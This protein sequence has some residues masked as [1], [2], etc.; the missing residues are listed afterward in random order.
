MESKSRLDWPDK[1]TE[2]CGVFAVYAPGEDVSRLVYFGLYALQHRGQESAG[3]GVADG[4]SVLVYK[5]MGLVPQVF[6]EQN[7]SSLQGYISI[8]HVRYSTTGSTKWE[9]SQPI[10]KTLP[11]GGSIALAH[12][13][14]LVNAKELR[15]LLEKKGWQFTSSSDSEIIAQLIVEEMS[16]S[17]E[18]A[19]KKAMRQLKGAYS[20]IATTE[21]TLYAFRDPYGIRPLAL[22]QFGTSYVISSETCGL[23]IVG[24]HYLRDIQPGEL[25][26]INSQ[27]LHSEKVISLPQ[28][29]LCIFEFIYFARPD[30]RLYGQLLYHARRAMGARLAEEAPV[31]ADLVIGIPDSGT[32]AAIGYAERSRI[33][34]SEG[35]IKNRY[36]GRTFIQPSQTIR[37]LGVRLKL[38]PLKEIIRG[39][40]LVIVDDSIVRGN[41]SKKIV[42]ILREA[43]A[44]E[45]HMRISSPPVRW[46][47]FYGID[48][49]TQ[50]ELIASAKSVEKIAHFIEADSLSYLSLE[51]LVKATK[52]P[53]A[54]FCLAC[55]NNAYPISVPEDV[56][57]DKFLLEKEKV[58][59]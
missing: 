15:D 59:S 35:L 1:M 2:A 53:E 22:G 21:D 49:A 18:E 47:C 58:S 51:G 5:D 17:V 8:G 29:S 24:A 39:K 50:V 52:R 55:F 6:N 14:N 33:P 46:P 32:P 10:H 45:I 54:D 41:T 38:N 48:T 16:E 30:S 44:K 37:Q 27:G 19:I 25:I 13:G 20:V 7:L 42:R 11:N 40:R 56:K 12:N 4:R 36:I 57:I 26:I 3:I 43:G 34:Y 9:N 31:K 28:N 23:D